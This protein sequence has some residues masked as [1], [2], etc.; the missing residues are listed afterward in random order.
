MSRYAIRTVGS[1][2]TPKNKPKVYVYKGWSYVVDTTR[3]AID[4]RISVYF[5]ERKQA[6]H[7][8]EVLIADDR[9]ALE[10]EAQLARPEPA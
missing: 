10:R 2:W 9:R 4:R 1:D 6:E 7:C 8:V 5:P 3:P